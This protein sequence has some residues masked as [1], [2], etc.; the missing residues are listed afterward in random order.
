MEQQ[1]YQEINT[2]QESKNGIRNDI[3]ANQLEIKGHERE[4]NLSEKVCRELRPKISSIAMQIQELKNEAESQKSPDISALEEDKEKLEE[5]L[6]NINE[7]VSKLDGEMDDAKNETK[8]FNDM[9]E[10]KKEEFDEIT[11]P[12]EPLRQRLDSI[13]NEY[14][15]SVRSQAHYK[16]KVQE[17]KA[18][19]EEK[20][21]IMEQ[22][23]EKYKK[24][25]EKAESFSK[26]P[27]ETRKKAEV[28][29]RELQVTEESIKRAENSHEPKELVEKKYREIRS[30]FNDLIQQIGCLKETVKYL[31]NMLRYR[32]KGYQELRGSICRIISSQFETRLQT[33]KYRGC[34]E[35]DHSCNQL[36]IYVDPSGEG[37]EINRR[38]MKTLSGGEKSYSTICLVLSL[39][40]EIQPPFRILDVFM[41]SINRRISLDLII[42]FAK[43]ERKSQYIFLTP[44]SLENLKE[45]KE[46]V[47]VVYFSKNEG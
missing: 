38:D 44:L 21:T 3:E 42:N 22:K 14:N 9:L 40:K 45:E 24:Q 18:A 37:N 36:Q 28:L 20:K 31:D 27:I 34:L 7:S 13:E 8:R 6:A 19:V 26:T 41:D 25:L 23:E 43:E 35:F 4:R 33:R 30:F 39:W 1:T 16:G 12:S 5:D 15:T 46:D 17:Y 47:T 10:K 29:F 11:K 2:L 32:K